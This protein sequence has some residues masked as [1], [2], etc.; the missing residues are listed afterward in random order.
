MHNHLGQFIRT[1]RE[2]VKPSDVGLPGGGRR[3]TA[4]LRREELAQLC[5]VS[6]A[7]LTWLEQGRPVSAS[8]RL[9]ASLAE[10]LHLSQAERHYLFD[11]ANKLDPSTGHP[12]GE[13]AGQLAAIV[14]AITAPAYILDRGWNAVASNAAARQLFAGWLDQP[15]G[16]AGAA[17]PNLLHFMFVQPQARSLIA[18]WPHRAARLVA[19]FRADTGKYADLEP[20]ATL[21]ADLTAHSTLFAQCWKEQNVV[22]REGGRRHFVHP[23]QGELT[24]DQVTLR[25][26]TRRELKLVMLLPAAFPGN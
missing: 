17:A 7:W 23:E 15:E 24:F 18:D 26:A 19:E 2:R 6:P 25:M 5:G 4:G 14:E 21:V 1:H 20:L 10:V 16:A 9:L 22:D 8:A 12:A 13:P 11:L 3:R